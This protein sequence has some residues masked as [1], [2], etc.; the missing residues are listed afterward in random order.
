[1]MQ[2]FYNIFPNHTPHETIIWGGKPTL[3][4]EKR[5]G[6]GV[7]SRFS[8]KFSGVI[9]L[10]KS[11]LLSLVPAP[12]LLFFT[13]CGATGNK[14]LSISSLYLATA[15]LAL[16]ILVGYLFGPKKNK[17]LVTLFTSILLVN[18]SYFALSI[19]QTIGQALWA[20]RV[21]YL[22]S[23]FL[24]FAML[25]AIMQMSDFKYHRAIPLSLTILAIAMF[26]IAGSPG[27]LDVYYRSV[28]IA[29]VDGATV[30]VKEYGPLHITYLFYLLGYFITTLYVV[31]K[32]IKK[33][34]LGNALYSIFL[35]SSVLI[36]I[37]VW[38]AEQFISLDF[39]LLSVSYIISEVF[40][41]AVYI[42]MYQYQKIAALKQQQT[43]DTI[44]TS[45]EDERLLF[46][47]NQ[48]STLTPT[49]K[50]VYNHYIQGK[51]TK[52]VLTL[53]NI[54]ENTLKYHNRNLYSKLGVSSKKELI[55]MHKS[56][57]E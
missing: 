52:E 35:A 10:T 47:K 44:S 42:M 45:Q 49:E 46:F 1:M 17:W 31:A 22:G 4:F 48:L 19:S 11:T 51:T 37:L 20:N 6:N 40:I 39:E 24:P 43:V 2:L 34:N 16:I 13:G 26:F 36:N 12:F 8:Y 9:L 15:V 25:M 56:I 53:L 30:L 50:V 29:V 38:L 28:E 41:L 14:N 5:V 32:Y 54:T 57:T 21:A 18:T 3:L 55:S 23:V 33:S 27:I 7:G